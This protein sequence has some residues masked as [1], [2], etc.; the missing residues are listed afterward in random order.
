MLSIWIC[1]EDEKEVIN[2]TCDEEMVGL[3]TN[4]KLLAAIDNMDDD[5]KPEFMEVSI[6][7]SET[8]LYIEAVDFLQKLQGIAPKL[9]VNAAATVHLESH[10]NY[11]SHWQ[12]KET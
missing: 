4:T 3:E 6:D 12:C 10:P 8:F 7:V 2:A 1:I 9:G 11:A 5:N